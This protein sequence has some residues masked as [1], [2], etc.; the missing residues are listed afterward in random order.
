MDQAQ[1]ALLSFNARKKDKAGLRSDDFI[2]VARD[3]RGRSSNRDSGS[4]HGRSRSRFTSRN[5]EVKCFQC[6]D[7]GHIRRNCPRKYADDKDKGDTNL[8]SGEGSIDCF[9][10]EEGGLLAAT[11]KYDASSKKEWE[12]DCDCVN[13]VCARK[14]AFGELQGSVTGKLNLADS[15]VDVMGGVVK[16]KTSCGVVHTLDGVAYVLKLRQNLISF[17]QLDSQGYECETHGGAVEV[18]KGKRVL[19]K[20]ELCRGYRLDGYAV[21]TSKGNWEWERRRRVSFAGEA[22]EC[23]Q[24]AHGGKGKILAGKVEGWRSLSRVI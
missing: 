17:T 23:F 1:A 11:E 5:S 12:L 14:D 20:G 24:A 3:G 13:H 18:T 9:L 6:G 2:G 4:K 19:V 8:A 22:T 15:T 10:I 16:N 21:K 7:L